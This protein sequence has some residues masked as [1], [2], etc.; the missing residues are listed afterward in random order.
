MQ[1]LISSLVAAA[2]VLLL[3]LTAGAQEAE[4]PDAET[5]EVCTATIA[6]IHAGEKVAVTATFAEPFGQIVAIE[7]SAESGL[8]LVTET[9]RA[10]G[11]MVEMADEA[12]AGVEAEAAVELAEEE[13]KAEAAVEAENATKFWLNAKDATAGTY[14]ITLKNEAD[15]SCATEITVEPKAAVEADATVE[16]EAA[17]DEDSEETEE[18]EDY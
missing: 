1:K 13:A 3:P 12:E 6:P 15:E 10:E 11:E 9:E 8:A 18:G 7:T 14:E 16:A 5:P 4:T 17:I 2:L